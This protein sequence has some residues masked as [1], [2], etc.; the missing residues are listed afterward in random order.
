[1]CLSVSVLRKW[2]GQG[3]H[4]QGLHTE[5]AEI[6]VVYVCEVTTAKFYL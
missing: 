5:E 4:P 3:G 1:V 6:T 2:G